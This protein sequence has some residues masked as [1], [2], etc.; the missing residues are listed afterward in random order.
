MTHGKYGIMKEWKI[1]WD[2]KKRDNAKGEEKGGN[3][4]FKK[5]EMKRELARQ[6]RKRCIQDE[7]KNSFL[8]SVSLCISLTQ[9]SGSASSSSLS[10]KR[11]VPHS[12]ALHSLAT[13]GR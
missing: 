9:Q 2:D 5:K 6:K 12:S 3:L 1:V 4:Y 11:A 7:K 8:L 13:E 10:Y